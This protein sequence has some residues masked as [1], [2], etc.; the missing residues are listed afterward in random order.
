MEREKIIQ[1]QTVTFNNKLYLVVLTNFGNLARVEVGTDNWTI[2][3]L[4]NRL[5]PKE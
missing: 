1:I 4:P 5:K 2:L 3:K